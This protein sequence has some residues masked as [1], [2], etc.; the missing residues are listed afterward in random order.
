VAFFPQFLDRNQ[1][2]AVQASLLLATFVAIET[3]WMIV[4]ASGGAKLAAWLRE[5]QRMRW[6]NRIA[7]LA[8]VAAGVLLG[9]FRR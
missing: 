8:F 5:G 7:G 3:G 1:P 2:L 9:A 6:F 4:Y